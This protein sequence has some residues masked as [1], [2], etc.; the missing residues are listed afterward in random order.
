MVATQNIKENGRWIRAGE[1]IPEEKP[2]EVKAGKPAAAEEPAAE[3]PKKV[4]A[5]PKSTAT[6]RKVS[7]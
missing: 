3:E 5:K 6:R 2:A 1:E 4:E 7:K